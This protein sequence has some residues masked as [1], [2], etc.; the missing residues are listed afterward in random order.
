MLSGL[1]AYLAGARVEGS[2]AVD[3]RLDS[4]GLRIFAVPGD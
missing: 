3:L 2:D 4:F 1:A